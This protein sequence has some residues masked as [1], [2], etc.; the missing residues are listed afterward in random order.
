M[1]EITFQ[2]A[3]ESSCD[4]KRHLS[5]LFWLWGQERVHEE[6]AFQCACVCACVFV[7]AGCVEGDQ[8]ICAGFEEVS[9]GTGTILNPPSW[10]RERGF[11]PLHPQQ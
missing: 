11:G 9:H 7:I 4:K 3:A 8:D 5:A 10:A 1:Q 6:R 2:R